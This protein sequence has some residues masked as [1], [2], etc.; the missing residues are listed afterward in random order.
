M[1]D[2]FLLEQKTGEKILF[3]ENKE[4]E[5]KERFSLLY[6][7][8]V[9]FH[10]SL[11]QK[12]NKP[13]TPQLQPKPKPNKPLFYLIMSVPRTFLITGANRGIGF[14]LTQTL[15][16]RNQKVI[17]TAR[18]LVGET[19]V[20]LRKLKDQKGDQLLLEALDV[21]SDDSA[22]QLA[23]RL[24]KDGVKINVLVNNAGIL[25]GYQTKF[26]ELSTSDLLEHFQTNTLGPFRVT[27]AVLPLLSA[28]EDGRPAII[29]TI[30]STLGSITQNTSGGIYAYRISKSAVNQWN[31]SLSQELK[32]HISIV[33][34]PGWVQTGKSLSLPVLF[35]NFFSFLFSFHPLKIHF[36]A[37]MGGANAALKPE[38]STNNIVENIFEKIT[39]QDTGKFISHSGAEIPY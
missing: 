14:Y 17:A 4:A 10:S 13:T 9:V 8:L 12:T 27:Q 15:L 16:A 21:T 22:K 30:S 33:I 6:Q 5:K 19:T 7:T 38:E 1:N 35:F 32:E 24:K 3:A 31:K 39:I 23:E 34:C 20:E 11:L 36:F 37:D 25:K 28:S 26:T 29:S 2:T 18:D